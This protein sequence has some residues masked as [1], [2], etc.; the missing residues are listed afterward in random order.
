MC[1]AKDVFDVSIL[2]AERILEAYE[3]M[4]NMPEFG[5]DPEELKRAA[6]IM[7]LTA[8]ETY[9]E[10]KVSEEVNLQSRVLQGSQLGDFIANS[11]EKELKFFHTPNSKK[12]KDIFERFLGIDVTKYWSWPGYEDPDRTRTKLNEWIKKRGDAVHRSVSDKQ[13][14]HLISKPEAEKCIKF[15][16]SLVQVTD[17]AISQN[18]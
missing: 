11:L 4:K 5:R 16:K 1:Q 18:H 13:T 2:D 17:T 8:W 9:V 6:L 12:T 10:D 7:S 14:S 3:H 15:L